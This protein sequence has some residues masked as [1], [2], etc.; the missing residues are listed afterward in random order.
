MAKVKVSCGTIDASYKGV[1]KPTLEA[2]FL[3]TEAERQKYEPIM[4]K[5]QEEGLKSS[6]TTIS[7]I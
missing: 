2:K 3:Q 6:G 4:K 7:G 5:L 1:A